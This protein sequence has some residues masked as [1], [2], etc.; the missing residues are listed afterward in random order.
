METDL[1]PTAEPVGARVINRLLEARGIALR[2]RLQAIQDATG[3]SYPQVRRRM[4]GQAEWTLDEL[5]AFAEYYGETLSSLVAAETS[6]KGNRATFHAGNLTMDC[7]V[8]IGEPATLS[9]QERLL[10]TRGGPRGWTVHAG[11][12]AKD[13]SAYEVEKLLLHPRKAARARIAILDDDFD[14]ATAI[15]AFAKARGFDASAFQN[16]ADLREAIRIEDFDAYILD[17]LL[18]DTTSLE[19]IA[20]IRKSGRSCPIIVLTGQVET[21]RVQESELTHAGL[22]YK[23]EVKEKPIRPSILL[24]SLELLLPQSD[25]AAS[26]DSQ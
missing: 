19:L 21:G 1:Q 23:L 8:W 18:N 3:L 15:A 26:L 12:D 14:S 24:N 13:G 6:A 7:I 22:A 11:H 9:H 25:S 4:A 10:A 5:R 2:Q 20:G 16:L 17:W